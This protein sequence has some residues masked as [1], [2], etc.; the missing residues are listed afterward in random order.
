MMSI[1]KLSVAMNIV[2]LSVVALSIVL[3]CAVMLSV[4]MLRGVAPPLK[5]TSFYKGRGDNY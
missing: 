2:L 4:V 5:G 3:L 1:V